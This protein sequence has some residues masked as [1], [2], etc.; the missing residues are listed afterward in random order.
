MY[1]LQKIFKNIKRYL[2]LLY[3]YNGVINII[4]IRLITNK[5][6]PM[7]LSFKQHITYRNS[8]DKKIKLDDSANIVHIIIIK[9]ILKDKRFD[10]SSSTIL[11][12]YT[13]YAFQHTVF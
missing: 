2:C 6:N 11:L 7:F 12:N 4:L 3:L 10:L 5:N 1:V 9:T 8:K 13:L